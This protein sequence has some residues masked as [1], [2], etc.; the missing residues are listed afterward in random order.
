MKFGYG[1][2][3]GDE[4]ITVTCGDEMCIKQLGI[5]DLSSNLRYKPEHL[6]D[7]SCSLQAQKN[8]KKLEYQV[9]RRK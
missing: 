2:T 3:C 1:V 9:L 8:K 5:Q 7:G 4:I 6:Q